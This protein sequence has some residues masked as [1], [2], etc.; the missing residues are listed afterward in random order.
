MQY[1]LIFWNSAH[2]LVKANDLEKSD[3]MGRENSTLKFKFDFE[4]QIWFEIQIKKFENFDSG[5]FF[6]LQSKTLILYSTL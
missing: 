5:F 2:I 6:L 1:I 4:I 3:R